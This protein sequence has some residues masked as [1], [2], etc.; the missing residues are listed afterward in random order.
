M[1]TKITTQQSS[2]I[3]TTVYLS[4]IAPICYFCTYFITTSLFAGSYNKNTIFGNMK[5]ALTMSQLLG[6]VVGKFLGAVLLA[7]IKKE[8]RL[9]IMLTIFVLSAVPLIIFGFLPPDGQVIA[10][11][12]GSIPFILSWG[13]VVFYVEGRRGTTLIVMII[14]L[15]LIMASGVSKTVA[16][17]LLENGVSEDWMPAVCSSGGMILCLLFSYLLATA[18]EPTSQEIEERQNRDPCTAEEQ[19]EFMNKYRSGLIII[20]IVYGITSAYRSF[21]DYYALEIW[22]ELLSDDFDT[23]VYSL[24]EILVSV[25]IALVYCMLVFIKDEKKGLMSLFYIMFTGGLIILVIGFMQSVF[26]NYAVAWIVTLGVGLYLSYVPP[27]ALLYD[28]LVGATKINYTSVF[29]VYISE[30]VGTSVSLLVILLKSLVF[31]D[32]SFV[33]YFIWLSNI[34]GIII[35]VG[36]ACTI[37]VFKYRLK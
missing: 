21:R 9:K 16:A 2:I 22:R 18:P 1:L 14:Y 28:K 30:L 25:A 4:I 3:K 15:A 5:D 27:G 20:N 36:M 33:Q 31:T 29:L 7:K 37:M 32:V 26:E 11:F 23:S 35:T 10:I 19:L 13:F 6:Y 34:T 12:V 24:S 17:K 8:N